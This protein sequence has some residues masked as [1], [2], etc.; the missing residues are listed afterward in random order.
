MLCITNCLSL[1]PFHGKP[2]A[3]Q[4]TFVTEQKQQKKQQQQK[5]ANLNVRFV[6]VCLFFFTLL[7]LYSYLKTRREQS[8]KKANKLT[9]F[10]L[11][12]G[13]FVFTFLFFLGLIL[14]YGFRQVVHQIK[15]C[16]EVRCI[17]WAH[18]PKFFLKVTVE[19]KTRQKSE[20]ARL[21]WQQR[22]NNAKI[23]AREQMAWVSLITSLFSVRIR[24]AIKFA[25]LL[26]IYCLNLLYRI[27]QCK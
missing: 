6:F 23:T 8:R 19:K 1:S 22:K 3:Q 25:F 18:L 26:I 4:K 27:S 14:N 16:V 24:K 5:N 15:L 7:Y 21:Q 12:F 2:P 9:V 11:H 10:C 20:W 13:R 17:K